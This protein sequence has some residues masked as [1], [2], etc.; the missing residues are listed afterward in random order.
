M[1]INGVELEDLDIYDVEV[2]EK[3]EKVL[4]NINK[5]QKVEGLKTSAVIRKQCE[6]IFNV[7][8]E[9]FGEGTDK[10]VF[11]DR[12]NLKICLEAFASLVDQINSQ[13]EELD[14]IVSKYS[15][16]RAQR[17]AKK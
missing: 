16:N 4:E 14:N 10:K 11:G 3:Y 7:F 17:R 9:L 12:V 6:A 8:N 1:I 5:P 2:A 15:P 13:K